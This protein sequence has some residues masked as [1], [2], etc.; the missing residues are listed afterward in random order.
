MTKNSE[1]IYLQ[2]LIYIYK[3]CDK[4]IEIISSSDKIKE[5][6]YQELLGLA[7]FYK[8]ELLKSAEIFKKLQDKY[9]YAYSLLL[10]NDKELCKP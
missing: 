7:Y 2:E 5:N 9:K 4:A 1:Y 3:N 10:L 8:S 6:K